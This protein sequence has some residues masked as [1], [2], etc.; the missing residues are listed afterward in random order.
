MGTQTMW[1]GLVTNPGSH[2]PVWLEEQWGSHMI[3]PRA[4]PRRQYATLLR[5]RKRCCCVSGPTG[6][7]TTEPTSPSQCVWGAS[8]C[9]ALKKDF[10]LLPFP[11]FAKTITSGFEAGLDGCTA[12]LRLMDTHIYSN[13]AVDC[14]WPLAKSRR[15]VFK[16]VSTLP[17]SCT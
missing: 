4:L 14:V 6:T 8:R 15:P 5:C 17:L 11:V 7:S 9:T 2:R 3:H 1:H 12:S 13:G 10:F 16:H